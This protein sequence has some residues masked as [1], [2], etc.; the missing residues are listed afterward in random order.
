[1]LL[2][3]EIRIRIKILYIIWYPTFQFLSENRLGSNSGKTYKKNNKTNVVIH[4]KNDNWNT[5]FSLV[6]KWKLKGSK[7][8]KNRAIN[9]PDNTAV[10]KL[11]KTGLGDGYSWIS[12]LS[13]QFFRITGNS[14][15]GEKLLFIG[16][17]FRIT[18]A[19]VL[20]YILM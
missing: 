12:I 11:L 7:Y 4:P 18:R 8:S 19:F 10:I 17:C 3:I 15:Y 6:F 16:L 9:N 13:I 14:L 1:M 20:V 2:N 5:L